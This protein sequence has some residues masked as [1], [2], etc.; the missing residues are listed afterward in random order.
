M[1]NL[2]KDRTRAS[3]S[4]GFN[5]KCLFMGYFLMTT[6]K[7]EMDI[8]ITTTIITTSTTNVKL[9]VV[10][11]VQLDLVVVIEAVVVVVIVVAA[12]CQA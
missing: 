9:V 1:R 12:I 5:Q 2:L 7:F 11:V 8:L 3:I 4:R 10:V 6:K